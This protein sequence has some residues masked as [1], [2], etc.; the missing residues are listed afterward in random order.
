MRSGS[1]AGAELADRS[2]NHVRDENSSPPTRAPHPVYPAQRS[3]SGP[4]TPS[5]AAGP[6]FRQA[7]PP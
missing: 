2:Q 1:R 7:V 6:I 4:A 3:L 5:L